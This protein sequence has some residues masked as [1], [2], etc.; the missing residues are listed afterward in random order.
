MDEVVFEGIPG[1]ENELFF[2]DIIVEQPQQ[3]SFSMKNICSDDIR[4]QWQSHPDFKFLPRFGHLRQN[5]TKTITVTC[6]SDRPARHSGVRVVCQWVRIRLVDSNAPDWDETQRTTRYVTKREF[7][8][9]SEDEYA[10]TPPDGGRLSVGRLAGSFRARGRLF[11][12]AM[13]D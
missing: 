2:S 9:H 6:A 8:E 11:L 5:E 4:F 7:A 10:P 3:I 12:L 13:H 1:D